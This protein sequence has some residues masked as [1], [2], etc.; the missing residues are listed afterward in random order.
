MSAEDPM[1]PPSHPK[2]T[3]EPALT[4]RFS[5]EGREVRAGYPSSDE[6]EEEA[7]PAASEL[8]RA[9]FGLVKQLRP[10]NEEGVMAGPTLYNHAGTPYTLTP[11][12][13]TLPHGTEVSVAHGPIRAGED[14]AWEGAD[15][16]FT[17]EVL[18]HCD[19][20]LTV[21]KT[22]DPRHHMHRYPGYT[23]TV[24]TRRLHATQGGEVS[25]QDREPRT[26]RWQATW[27][28][29]GSENPLH[30]EHCLVDGSA[31]KRPG[32]RDELNTFLRTL[33]AA[34][35]LPAGE[36]RPEHITL[37][38]VQPV[39]NCE[40]R[41]IKETCAFRQFRGERF[42][43][44]TSTV[45]Q[46]FQDIRDRHDNTILGTVRHALSVQFLTA[47]RDHYHHM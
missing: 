32:D 27:S 41:P 47:V 28:P 44:T 6:Q 1:E 3:F 35:Y 23:E 22:I 43:L 26:V 25:Q 46:G 36:K 12:Q 33:L 37:H 4:V 9:P 10:T 42:Y 31:L 20:G 45:Q 13:K 15:A 40:P 18:H 30:T 16:A 17:A 39:C 19:T 11:A 5:Y 29:T 2:R 14:A 38:D 8:L 21:I 34:T 7:T 24:E